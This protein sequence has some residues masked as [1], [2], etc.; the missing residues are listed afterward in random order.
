MDRTLAAS[1]RWFVRLLRCY[2]R[3]FR[4]AYGAHVAQVF[5]DSSREALAT[6]GARGLAGLWLATLPDLLKTATQ[7][8]VKEL[9]MNNFLSDPKTRAQV[10]FVLCLPLAAITLLSAVGVDPSS[11]PI[12]GNPGI[13]S[14]IALVMML[15]GLWLYGAP[16]GLSA[17]IGLLITAPFAAM[18]LVNRRSYGE[19]FPFPLFGIMWLMAAVFAAI[20]IPI[21]KDVRTGKASKA[22]WASLL[23]RGVILVGVIIGWVTLVADQMPCFLG[24]R[25]CD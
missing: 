10:A 14:G 19:D 7:E 2:P 16:T 5:R 15:L 13:V 18:E 23:V 17:L 3:S 8:H 6:A 24:V 4:Q 9:Q 1:Q 21:T 12:P 25:Y 20:L 22:N 11:L